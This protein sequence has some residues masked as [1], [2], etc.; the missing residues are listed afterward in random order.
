MAEKNKYQQHHAAKFFRR[1]LRKHIWTFK[2]HEKSSKVAGQ[3][4][5]ND[6]LFLD[7][8]QFKNFELGVFYPKIIEP[9]LFLASKLSSL[10]L[11]RSF[12]HS[13]TLA[14][15]SFKAEVSFWLFFFRVPISSSFF[16]FSLDLKQRRHCNKVIGS[17]KLW[18]RAYW[19]LPVSKLD[20][21][22][23]WH[24]RKIF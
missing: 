15:L 24:V 4:Q 7:N 16:L 11:C 5:K 3:Q 6:V 14:A 19:I 22:L 17:S 23:L 18:L 2:T 20:L 8:E 12:F 9:T 21:K 10:Y 1:K 13:S